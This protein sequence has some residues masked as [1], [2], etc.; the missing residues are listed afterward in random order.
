M[1]NKKFAGIIVRAAYIV[2]TGETHQVC[3]V[4]HS[5]RSIMFA[6]LDCKVTNK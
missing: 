2:Q 3:P 5:K 4:F 1:Q 6:I